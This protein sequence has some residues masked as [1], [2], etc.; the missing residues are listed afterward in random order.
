[1]AFD[2]DMIKA[3]YQRLPERLAAAK[4]ILGRPMTLTEKILFAHFTDSPDLPLTDSKTETVNR[5]T[6]APVRGVSYI[7]FQPDRVAMQD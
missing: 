7:D 3:V 5:R 4:K 6:G 1:M 2:F